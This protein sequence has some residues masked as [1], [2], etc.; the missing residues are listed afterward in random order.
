MLKNAESECLTT[1]LGRSQNVGFCRLVEMFTASK[2]YQRATRRQRFECEPIGAAW[3]GRQADRPVRVDHTTPL[4]ARA[5]RTREGRAGLVLDCRR[6]SS[7]R[8]GFSNQTGGSGV[9]GLDDQRRETGAPTPIK[10]AFSSTEAPPGG[11]RP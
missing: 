8:N 9:I 7:P 11:P 1:A 5:T 6:G 4:K 10:V 3:P 2:L